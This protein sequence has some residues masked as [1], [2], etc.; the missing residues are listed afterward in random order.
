MSA[1]LRIMLPRQLTCAARPA[2]GL[3][4]TTLLFLLAAF[5]TAVEA[6]AA[7]NAA[8]NSARWTPSTVR[9]GDRVHPVYIGRWKAG[10][11]VAAADL[12]WFDENDDG[13]LDASDRLYWRRLGV[14]DADAR[15]AT[16][17][18][19]P[20]KLYIT[21]KGA[22]RRTLFGVRPVGVVALRD[23]NLVQGAR[24]SGR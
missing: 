17:D 4:K 1:T 13:V 6:S 23:V 12:P 16:S 20:R 18:R 8:P 2:R 11:R 15:R 24:I 3:S 14:R 7:P 9:I 10:E 19:P 22:E 5:A 21:A